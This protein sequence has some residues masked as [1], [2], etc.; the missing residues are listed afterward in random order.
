MGDST[1]H[2]HKD[3]NATTSSFKL[4]VITFFVD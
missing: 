1:L 3:S 4:E 2:N